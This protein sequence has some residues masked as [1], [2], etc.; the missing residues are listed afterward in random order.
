MPNSWQQ[1]ESGEPGGATWHKVADPSTGNIASKTS[2]WTADEFQST[3][4]TSHFEVDFSSVVPAGAK[5]VR[6]VVYQ[7]TTLSA[8]YWRKAG[9]SNISNTPNASNEYS[10]MILSDQDGTV[11][12]EVWLS[13]SYKADFSVASA[14]TDLYVCYPTEYLL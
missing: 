9:D 1:P 11:V 7:A 6:V 14:N 12:A 3:G 2:G 8:V 13:S 10:H 5:A 4:S